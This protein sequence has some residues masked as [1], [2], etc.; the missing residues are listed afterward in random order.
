MKCRGE[1]GDSKP[2]WGAPKIVGYA[3][4]VQLEPSQS[5]S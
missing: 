2:V 4:T 3:S 1:R 5:G